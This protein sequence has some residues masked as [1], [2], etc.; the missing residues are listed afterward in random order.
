[1]FTIA[2]HHNSNSHRP[3]IENTWHRRRTWTS[4]VDIDQRYCLLIALSVQLSAYSM[5][6]NWA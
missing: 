3:V 2:K 1:M 4:A 5:I 6:V